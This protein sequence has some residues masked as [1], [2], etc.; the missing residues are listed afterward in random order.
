M[1]TYKFPIIWPIS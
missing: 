1:H